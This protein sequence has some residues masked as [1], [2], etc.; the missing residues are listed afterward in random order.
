VIVRLKVK[1]EQTHE[2]YL[3]LSA[4]APVPFADS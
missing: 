3:A 1:R 4:F 2:R